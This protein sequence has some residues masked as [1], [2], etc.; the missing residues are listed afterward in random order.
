MTTVAAIGKFEIF[1]FPQKSRVEEMLKWISPW[2]Y[3]NSRSGDQIVVGIRPVL[4]S[5]VEATALAVPAKNIPDLL[6]WVSDNAEAITGPVYNLPPLNAEFVC[7]AM[8]E[9]I[10]LQ[11]V[12]FDPELPQSVLQVLDSLRNSVLTQ[13]AA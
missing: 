8:Q 3:S 10:D 7:I 5:W 6:V 4:G 9:D 11:N 13:S 1:S 2:F 12:E